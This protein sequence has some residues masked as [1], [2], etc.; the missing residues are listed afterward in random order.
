MPTEPA[1][2]GRAD[3]AE[4]TAALRHDRTLLACL[5]TANYEVGTVQPVGDVAQECQRN[6]VPL[7]VD[8]AASIGRLPLPRVRFRLVVCRAEAFLQ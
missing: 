1:S 2:S 7:L 8:A 5:Q 4:F 3:V 6:Q